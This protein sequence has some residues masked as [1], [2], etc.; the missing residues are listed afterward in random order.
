VGGG[1]GER[2]W[3]GRGVNSRHGLCGV[4]WLGCLGRGGGWGGGWVTMAR[5]DWG[6]VWRGGGGCWFC[7]DCFV[8]LVLVVH[9]G[10]VGCVGEVVG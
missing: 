7:R 2:G 4:L 3:R 8:I 6:G 1:A 5:C 10:G 9:G